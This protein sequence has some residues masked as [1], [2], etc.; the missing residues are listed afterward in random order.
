MQTII[1]LCQLSK[2]VILN[3][4]SNNPEKN[5]DFYYE[6]YN[7]LTLGAELDSVNPNSPKILVI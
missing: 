5:L 3:R 4:R 2:Q 7:K 6:S 1:L